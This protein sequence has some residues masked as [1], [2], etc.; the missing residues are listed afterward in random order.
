MTDFYFPLVISVNKAF[1]ER[2]V[3]FWIAE[4]ALG[5]HTYTS[6]ALFTGPS[7]LAIRLPCSIFWPYRDIKPDNILLDAAG[8]A[9]HHNFN[10]AIHYSD[11]RLI[12]QLQAPWP[13]WPRQS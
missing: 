4:L 1:P 13:T 9:A 11:R 10:V 2:V 5:L 7:L 8:Q 6:N 12:H 3:R